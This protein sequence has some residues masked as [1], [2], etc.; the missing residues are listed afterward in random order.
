MYLMCLT[1]R[2]AIVCRIDESGIKNTIRSAFKVYKSL[3]ITNIYMGIT[4]MSPKF[5]G[6]PTEIHRDVQKVRQSAFNPIN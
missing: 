3:T 1:S 2:E 5:T 6:F 4:A